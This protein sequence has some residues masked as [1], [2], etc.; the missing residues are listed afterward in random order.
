MVDYSKYSCSRMLQYIEERSRQLGKD[1]HIDYI[2]SMEKAESIEELI[3]KYDHTYQFLAILIFGTKEVPRYWYKPEMWGCDNIY[4]VDEL[5]NY[6]NE[7]ILKW[8]QKQES[9]TDLQALNCIS[10]LRH[11]DNAHSIEERIESVS[12]PKA[13]KGL[14]FL[15]YVRNRQYNVRKKLEGYCKDQE[16]F[17]KEYMRL[18]RYLAAHGRILDVVDIYFGREYGLRYENLIE[19]YKKDLAEEREREEERKKLEK[20][21]KIRQAMASSTET[22][23]KVGGFLGSFLLSIPFG[24]L[25]AV[26]SNIRKG[27]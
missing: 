27:K 6:F 23:D 14:P 4:L 26:F 9:P 2:L 1:N 8:F 5:D 19:D 10:N 11:S 22:I 16:F 17:K 18:T 25:G 3:N 20:E 21:E 12:T 15:K 24:F 13:D 7:C